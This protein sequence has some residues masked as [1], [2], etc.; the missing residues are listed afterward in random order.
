MVVLG[1]V[2]VSR[3]RGGTGER[4]EATLPTSEPSSSNTPSPPPVG[5]NKS[6][7]DFVCCFS[8]V[9]APA[10]GASTFAM[11]S[12]KLLSCVLRLPGNFDENVFHASATSDVL[13]DAVLPSLR[14]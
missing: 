7:P 6:P 8:P 11:L 10:V 4:G 12:S 13:L 3:V 9:P 1:L 14:W 5:R 2:E